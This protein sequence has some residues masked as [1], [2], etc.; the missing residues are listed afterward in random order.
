MRSPF[1]R[2]LVCGVAL[3]IVAV[4]VPSAHPTGGVVVHDGWAWES[5]SA[6][7]TVAFVVIENHTDK[8]VTLVAAAVDGAGEVEFRKPAAGKGDATE[9]VA[10][11]EIAAEKAV[12]LQPG[13]L[14]LALIDLDQPLKA[15]MKTRL[16]LG[17]KGGVKK[18]LM[19]DVRKRPAAST[20]R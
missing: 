20:S 5:G 13:A 3:A 10:E 7:E 15:G 12:T 11:I 4:A 19:I 6:S 16:T 18:Q 9:K 14:H 2:E 17:F 1:L 8:A